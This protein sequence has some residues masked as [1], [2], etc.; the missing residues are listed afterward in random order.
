MDCSLLGSSVHGILQARILKRVAISFSR[1]STQPRDWTWVSCVAGR[2]F[3]TS[4]ALLS[5]GIVFILKMKNQ[6]QRGQWPSSD[7]RGGGPGLEPSLPNLTFSHT[8]KITPW[9]CTVLQPCSPFFLPLGF[10]RVL[11]E[12]GGEPWASPTGKPGP[13]QLHIAPATCKGPA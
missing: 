6:M 5:T 9:S 4:E 7:K 11:Y 2:F 10:I 8:P 1:G 13:R 3:T 12:A